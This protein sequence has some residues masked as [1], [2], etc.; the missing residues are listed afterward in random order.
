MRGRRI[1]LGVGVLAAMSFL[2]SLLVGHAFFE[3]LSL[4]NDEAVYVLQAKMFAGGDVTLSDAAH[5]DAFRPWMSGR[6]EGDRLVLVEQPTLPALMALSDIVF[7]TMRVAVALV[8]AGAVVA[9]FALARALLGDDR[10]AIVAA[11]CFVLS[12]L[13]IVQSAM[14]LS[15][16]LAITLAAAALASTTHGIDARVAGRSATGW[17]IA[18]GATMG[19]LL[20]TRPLEG[21]VLTVLLFGWLRVRGGDWRLAWRAAVPIGLAVLPVLVLA[22]VYNEFTTG[23]PFV[24]ALWTIGGDD[25]FGFGYRSIAEHAQHVYVGPWEA[26]LALRVNLRAFPHWIV[27]GLASVPLA[28]W[29][30]WR[31]WKMSRTTFWLV[32]AMLVAYPLAYFFYYGNYLIIAGRNF[33]GPHYYLALLL[34]SMLLLGVALTDLASRRWPWLT[35]AI[36][37]MVVG[38]SIELPNKIRTNRET[39]DAIARE[40]A[41]VRSSVTPP[42]V[43]LLP[44]SADG[45]YVLHPW[46]AFGNSPHLDDAT[47][48][49]ADLGPRNLELLDRFPDRNLYRFEMAATAESVEP[50]V[51]PL[52]TLRGPRLRFSVDA[53]R[54]DHLAIGDNLLRCDRSSTALTVIVSVDRAEVTGCTPERTALRLHHE[55]TSLRF[56]TSRHGASG[57]QA[58]GGRPVDRVDLVYTVGPTATDPATADMVTFTPPQWFAPI[59]PFDALE[60]IDPSLAPWATTSATAAD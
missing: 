35:A 26:W 3:N 33:Y 7:G 37:A 14:Y 18:G 53:A 46:G 38:T 52:H 25:S 36:L 34:P 31:L 43:V 8:A 4:N 56:G 19:L 27:G 11:A 16:V 1:W 47:L 10:I 5:G 48:F 12:P 21:I 28:A 41:A 45:P 58:A 59:G 60:A 42:A 6:V 30:G 57:Q 51:R 49:S 20:L 2:L 17:L 29:G 55:R 40:V 9:V 39:R 50:M 13:V 23:T 24:F 32:V 15:Y 44:A 54:V 22:F